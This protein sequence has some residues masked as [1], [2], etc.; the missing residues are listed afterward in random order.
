MINMS[1]I[2][3]ELGIPPDINLRQVVA[4]GTNGKN[5]GRARIIIAKRIDKLL[6]SCW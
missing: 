5:N 2:F 6:F 4:Q 1:D 3:K